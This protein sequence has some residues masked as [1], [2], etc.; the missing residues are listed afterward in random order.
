MPTLLPLVLR[1][2]GKATALLPVPR[3]EGG[4]GALRLFVQEALSSRKL[5]V[6]QRQRSHQLS[7]QDG[8]TIPED[9]LGALLVDVEASMPGAVRLSAA[10][11]KASPCSSTAPLQSPLFAEVAALAIPGGR[12]KG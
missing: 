1:A 5:C 4:G 8:K 9:T 10:S 3:R 11:S 12:R 7:A 2:G 6:A